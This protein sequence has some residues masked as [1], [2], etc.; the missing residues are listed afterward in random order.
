MPTTSNVYRNNFS[1]TYE[2]ILRNMLERAHGL[3]ELPYRPFNGN[4]IAPMNED[5]T[6][7]NSL[8]RQEGLYSPYFNQAQSMYQSAAKP[9]HQD[10]QNYM[11]PYI[12][13][14]LD[15]QRTEGLRTF[16]EGIMPALD[17]RFIQGGTFR[18]GV[19]REMA[20]RAAR[21]VQQS[22][23]DRQQQTLAGAYQQAAQTHATDT[24][25]QLQAAGRIADLGQRR[26]A[27]NIADIA[28]LE[29]Q[30]DRQRGVAQQSLDTRYRDFLRQSEYPQAQLSGL[31][32]ALAGAP[33]S[34]QGL[35]YVNTPAEPQLNRMG[36]MAQL[37]GQLY[38]AR[39]AGVFKQ[40]GKVAKKR[41]AVRQG[42][43]MHSGLG[44]S[45]RKKKEAR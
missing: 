10:Y 45:K 21:D 35:Q 7:A 18:G 5:L 36:Q 1:P 2:A 24:D 4:R 14:I 38:G 8:G 19:H 15:K 26:Q 33:Q 16:N 27:G 28:T 37:S 17:S 6:R 34:S 41:K 13:S 30:G 20:G 32:S 22:I 25:R 44:K 11:N 9:F 42:L 43:P 29:N 3:S 23:A 40:G 31:T 39:Q 12:Q